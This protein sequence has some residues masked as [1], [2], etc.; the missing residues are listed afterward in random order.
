MKLRIAKK[1]DNKILADIHM[2]CGKIQPDGFMHQLGLTFLRTYY[3]ILINEK[4]SIILLAEDENDFIHG[5]CSGT[6]AAEEHLEKLKKHKVKLAFSLIPA[7]LKSPKL[8]KNIIARNKY[9]NTS[10]KSVKFGVSLGSRCEYWAWRPENK[11][12]TMSMHLFNVWRNIVFE[13]G[14]ESIKGEVDMLNKYILKIH[15]ILG[16]KII[17]ELNLPDGRSRV[18]I[19]Y[20]K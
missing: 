18:I 7:L 19:E 12:L 9:I 1:S 8:L 2:E 13:L 17:E 10:V 11:N 4:K 5:F 14:S 20:K 16:A 6:M 3:A 15:K